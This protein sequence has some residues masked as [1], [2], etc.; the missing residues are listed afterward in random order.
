MKERQGRSFGRR[1][2]TATAMAA[3]GAALL[4]GAASAATPAA[5][6]GGAQSVSDVSA[7]LTGTVDPQGQ[8]TR[9]FFQYGTSRSYGS[10]TGETDA[11][12][13]QQA[14]HVA[15]S[16]ASLAPLTTYHFRLV[17][18][19]ASGASTGSDV[20][21]TTPGIPLSLHITALP[22]PATFGLAASIEGVLTGSGAA[23]RPVELQADPFPYIAGF[24][25]VGNA[26]LT[27]P[28]GAFSFALPAMSAAAEYRAVTTSPPLLSSPVLLENVAVAVSAHLS[29]TRRRHVARFYGT[30]TP[31][32]TGMQIAV[33]RMSGGRGLL[34]GGALLRPGAAGSSRFSLGV[35]VRPGVYR[36][37]A[38][39]TD[40]AHVSAYS[41]PLR[42]G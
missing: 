21:F 3:T 34:V 6:T 33:L 25:S 2:A 11:G 29:S 10:A 38:R 19:N 40:G 23:G 20:S 1:L 17:A 24:S 5:Q 39:V 14:V 16:V 31:D 9:Y 8:D 27:G 36:V 12:S 28:T 35:R 13:F 42:V 7:V 37:L 15:T 41:V 4:A 18:L 30:V 22:D 32:E 26:E